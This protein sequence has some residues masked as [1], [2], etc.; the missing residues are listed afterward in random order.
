MVW[1]SLLKGPLA[2]KLFVTPASFGRRTNVFWIFSAI[3]SSCDVGITFKQPAGLVHAA[4]WAGVDRKAFRPVPS[5][6]PVEGSKTIPAR[7][8]TEV[9]AVVCAI[10][11]EA[12]FAE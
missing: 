10:R 9:P 12:P 2:K 5:A 8:G 11:A 6:A 7:T 4:F 3:A 1:R